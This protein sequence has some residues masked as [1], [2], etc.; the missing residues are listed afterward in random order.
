MRVGKP[1]AGAE[2]SPHSPVNV[3]APVP[4]PATEAILGP[5]KRHV[6]R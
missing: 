6:T 3:P 5:T 1:R 4:V 2:V